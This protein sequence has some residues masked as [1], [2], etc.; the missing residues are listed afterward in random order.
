MGRPATAAPSPRASR[1]SARSGSRALCGVELISP[2]AAWAIARARRGVRPGCSSQSRSAHSSTYLRCSVRTR[3][4]AASGSEAQS[5]SWTTISGL[6]RS[7]KSTC[8]ATSAAQRRGGVGGGLRALPADGQQ[9]LADVDEHLG[10]HGV[11]GREVLV[12]RRAG[13]PARRAELD[14]RDAVE[15]ALGEQGRGGAEDLL[16]TGG[17][18]GARVAE[19]LTIA[20]LRSGRWRLATMPDGHMTPGGRAAR[21]AGRRAAGRLG[22][23]ARASTSTAASCW[24][25]TGSTG[26]STPAARSSSSS[27]LAAT[28]MYGDAVPV[29]RHRHRHRPGQ[30]PRVRGRR[31]RRHRQG[32]HLLP[33]D[34]QEAPARAGGGPGQ[35]AAVP[36][37]RRLRR[38]VPADA[39]RGVPR[40]GALRPDLLQPG[41]PL[42]PAA[43]RRSPR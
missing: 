14:D 29:R 18:H 28:G 35:P 5:R 20:N 6:W 15:A 32:R 7:A 22:V 23:R 40:P 19:W 1:A 2:K 42:R 27:P 11:L 12:E 33:D 30:R 4:R 16:A 36:L 43:S 26:C 39:G 31:Q 3:S 25:A 13:D 37:P 9:L 24:P 38:R 21:A 41:Q 10:E 17:G 8:Q 34:G